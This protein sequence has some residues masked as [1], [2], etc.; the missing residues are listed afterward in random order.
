VVERDR[1]ENDYTKCIESS[2]LSLSIL[3][4]KL[5]RRNLRDSYI[6]LYK[7]KINKNMSVQ[8]PYHLVEPSPWPILAAMSAFTL[9]FGGVL[10]MHRFSIGFLVLSLGVLFLSFIFF[11]WFRDIIREANYQGL[12]T[13]RVQYGLKAGMVLFIVSEVFFFVAFFW[14]FFHSALS[15]A[16]DIGAVWPPKGI[17]VLNPFEVPLLNTV[18]LLSSGATITWAHHAIIAKDKSGAISGFLLTILFALI[19]T[20]LQ[21]FEY[22]HAPFTIADGIYGTTFFMT[23]G[24]H[25]FH[26]LIG[27]TFI[28]VCFFRLLTNNFT[29]LHHLGFE[30]AAWYW[31]FVD[32]V[33]IFLFVTIYWWGS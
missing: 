30:A 18:I 3:L 13:L 5:N 11:V 2:N 4:F 27:T 21:I 17:D 10:Y 24:F 9:T 31:H 29:N 28:S 15:P 22:K 26:V 12:H 16:I 23:T 1:L 6:I 32:V 25:G 8:H 19:F 14:A 7:K 33:W 20:A